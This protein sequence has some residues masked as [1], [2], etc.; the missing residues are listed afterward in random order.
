VVDGIKSGG[1][2]I[3][4]GMWCRGPWTIDVTNQ[5]RVASQVYDAAEN[6]QVQLAFG[7]AGANEAHRF[8]TREAVDEIGPVKAFPGANVARGDELHERRL[9]FWKTGSDAKMFCWECMKQCRNLAA[10]LKL[11]K[12]PNKMV[13]EILGNFDC[14]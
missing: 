12:P 10:P 14:I 6:P 1:F 13:K 4:Q 5:G 7:V 3:G 8:K 2:Y 9:I 11:V